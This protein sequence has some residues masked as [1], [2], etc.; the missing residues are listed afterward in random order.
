MRELR[1]LMQKKQEKLSDFQAELAE[2]RLQISEL[3][4]ELALLKVGAFPFFILSESAIKSLKKSNSNAKRVGVFYSYLVKISR[5]SI[6][7]VL[8][9]SI[10]VISVRYFPVLLLNE[11]LIITSG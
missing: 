8:I 2:Q 7:I 1:A 3:K 9:T 5:Q 10:S 6:T 11:A 4:R